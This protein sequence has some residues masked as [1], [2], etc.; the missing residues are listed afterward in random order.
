MMELKD[1]YDIVR[2]N[3]SDIAECAGYKRKG[4]GSITDGLKLLELKG[5]IYRIDKHLYKVLI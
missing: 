1:E 4:G 2:A 5:K 3:N